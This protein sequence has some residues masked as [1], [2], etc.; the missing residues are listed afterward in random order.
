M[1]GWW[2]GGITRGLHPSFLMGGQAS[3]TAFQ[4]QI[5]FSFGLVQ[6]AESQGS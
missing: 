1:G 6:T 3:S 2:G 4:S 5:P